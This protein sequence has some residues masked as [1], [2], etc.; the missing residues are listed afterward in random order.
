[1]NVTAIQA[2]DGADAIFHA[3]LSSLVVQV[4]PFAVVGSVRRQ[5]ATPVSVEPSL[6]RVV[7]SIETVT[8]SEVITGVAGD[9]L[10]EGTPLW[11]AVQPAEETRVANKPSFMPIPKIWVLMCDS[12]LARPSFDALYK[13]R[14]P[15]RST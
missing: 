9:V 4:A 2:L 8:T 11:A 12:P 15:S 14:A 3:P 7:P 10:V 1:M 13:E 5:T 6:A